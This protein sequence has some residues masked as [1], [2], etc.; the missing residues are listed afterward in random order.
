MII[1]K[2]IK[3][4]SKFLNVLASFEAPYNGKITN[5][6]D[7]VLNE[8]DRRV[9]TR[10]VHNKVYIADYINDS[11][12]WSDTLNEQYFRALHYYTSKQLKGNPSR[13]STTGFSQL[14][15]DTIVRD[16]DDYT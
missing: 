2:T 5:G 16:E 8:I 6:V 3:Y 7:A 9:A 13:I 15:E 10:R 14:I 4:T 12:C 1:R 11:F